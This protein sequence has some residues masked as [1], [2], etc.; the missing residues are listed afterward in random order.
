[1]RRV[2]CLI[3]DSLT[4]ADTKFNSCICISINLDTTRRPALGP[5]HPPN[6]WTPVAV[7]SETSEQTL[8]LTTYHR[9]V[10]VLRT[11][12]AVPPLKI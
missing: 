1:M 2:F 6:Q 11:H 9:I 8:K 10:T 7:L 3:F 4:T 12:G 5:T